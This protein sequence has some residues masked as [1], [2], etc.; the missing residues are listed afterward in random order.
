MNKSALIS[1]LTIIYANFAV[2]GKIKTYFL[3][4]VILHRILANCSCFNNKGRYKLTSE[5]T[6]E[7]LVNSIVLDN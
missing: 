2:T 4:L 7:K 6:S 1:F 5:L 3:V